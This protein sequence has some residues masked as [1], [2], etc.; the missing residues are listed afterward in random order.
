MYCVEKPCSHIVELLILLVYMIIIQPTNSASHLML[1]QFSTIK[2]NE[3]DILLF[4][5]L[6]LI[7]DKWNYI[8]AFNVIAYMCSLT[9]KRKFILP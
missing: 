2:I 1:A 7:I 8:E 9:D 3:P 6:F 5:G 4:K